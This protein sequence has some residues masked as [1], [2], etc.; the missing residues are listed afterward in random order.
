MSEVVQIQTVDITPSSEEVLEQQGV[1][2]GTQVRPDID[3]ICANALKLFNETAAPIGVTAGI[4][5]QE[6][7]YVF[8]GEGKNE[9]ETPVG[10]IFGQAQHLLLFAVTLGKETSNRIE[11]LFHTN[12]FALGCMLDAAASVAADKAATFVEQQF[13]L[14]LAESGWD[15]QSGA[16]LRYSPGYCGWN[17]SGQKKLFE[18]LEPERIGLTLR[19]SCLMEPLK[20]VSGVVLAGP[21]DMHEFDPSY[22]SCATCETYSCRDRIHAL[23][24]N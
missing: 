2:P 16:A 5:L 13:A 17:I 9:A 8:E 15:L 4:A 14:S 11:S 18:F 22:P 6:F 3:T 12:D 1:P 24:A 7:A 10:D 20:S 21:R 23:F 19:A